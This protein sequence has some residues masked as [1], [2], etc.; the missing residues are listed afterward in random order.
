[1]NILIPVV[2]LYHFDAIVL[3]VIGVK[4]YYFNEHMTYLCTKSCLK[5]IITTLHDLKGLTSL[6]YLCRAHVHLVLHT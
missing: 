6:V 4:Q 2:E 1:M 3:N 5:H